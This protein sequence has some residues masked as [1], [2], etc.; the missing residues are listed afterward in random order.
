MNDVLS[1]MNIT[2]F[3]PGHGYTAYS[4]GLFFGLIAVGID[5]GVVVIAWV[6][7]TLASYYSSHYPS[8]GNPHLQ[9]RIVICGWLQSLVAIFSGLSLSL[10]ACAFDKLLGTITVTVYLIGVGISIYYMQKRWNW[11]QIVKSNKW[12][13]TSFVFAVITLGLSVS[14]FNPC[15][16]IIVPAVAATMLNHL[17]IITPTGYPQRISSMITWFMFI[18]WAGALALT[19][20]IMVTQD[21]DWRIS[22]QLICIIIDMA[23]PMAMNINEGWRM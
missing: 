22:L 15:T 1:A 5:L 19:V 6:N 23:V 17:Q 4:M 14:D 7:A 3:G 12:L 13:I 18:T 9:F 10:L 16:I 11:L 8:D 20:V 2:L 21:P